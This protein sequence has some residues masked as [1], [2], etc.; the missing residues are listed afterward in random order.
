[1]DRRSLLKVLMAGTAVPMVLSSA[2]GAA[3]YPTKPITVICNFPA[4]NGSDIAVRFFSEKLSKRLGQP[5]VVVNR[6]GAFGLIGARA[7]AEAPADGYTLFITG[8]STVI[9]G[10]PFLYKDVPYDPQKAFRPVARLHNLP[11]VLTVAPNSPL[12]TVS[13][14]TKY[15]KSDADIR[16]YG[17]AANPGTISAEMYLQQIGKKLDRATYRDAKQAMLE[18]QNGLVSF[19]F[20][21]AT[22][23]VGAVRAQQVRPLAVTSALR[24]PALPD[25]PTM[26][27]AGLPG[28]EMSL[29][30]AVMTPSGVPDD[31]ARILENAVVEIL[32]DPETLDFIG[33]IGAVP[34]PGTE[35]D[36]RLDIKTE[37]VKWAEYARLASIEPQ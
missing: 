1:M 35:N 3:N 15:L 14:L 34:N 19:A 36:L 24:M 10:A 33:K 22:S 23:T 16:P 28:Y 31:I 37:S 26:Q 21:D 7:A 12:K 11:F 32:K 9:A 29:T 27:E 20:F 5:L 17:T 30:W 6:I 18:L 13:D 4:G 25:V 8:I 2:A